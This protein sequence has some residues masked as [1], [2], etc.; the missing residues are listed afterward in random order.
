M[1]KVDLHIHTVASKH[2]H[3]TIL[4]Y[5]NQAKKLKMKIIGISDH[6]PANV[7]TL[8]DQIYFRELKRMPDVI[9]GIRVLKGVEANIVNKNGEIDIEDRTIARLDYV[10]AGMHRGS[11]YVDVGSR[12]NTEAYIKTIRSGRVRILTHPFYTVDFPHD[13]AEMTDA[14]CRHGVLL[15]VN[16]SFLGRRLTPVLL[17]NIKTMVAVVKKNRKKLIINSDAHNI[18][19]L[20]NDV[21]LKKYKKQI[22][23][24][25]D[26]V[27][28]NYPKEL[29]ELLKLEK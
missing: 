15:E 20:G 17:D 29:F 9:N 18:W 7:T 16:L 24:T 25:D 26:L 23:L 14:A 5:V 13:I 4:E 6:G 1:L 3:N 27:I 8:T 21:G 28:N 11:P 12:K 22:G 2:A 19:E 10:M